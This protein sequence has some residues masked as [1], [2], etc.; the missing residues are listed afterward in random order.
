MLEMKLNK[1]RRLKDGRY[2]F[3]YTCPKTHKFK[4]MR[5]KN[6]QELSDRRAAIQKEQGF[7]GNSLL[8]DQTPL[9]E[10]LK[11]YKRQRKVD[12]A[13][14]K[15]GRKSAETYESQLGILEPYRLDDVSVEGGTWSFRFY[16]IR[17]GQTKI[18]R[19]D[20]ELDC[21][22]QHRRVL[23]QHLKA[24]E[25][26][27]EKLHMLKQPMSALT[28][29]YISRLLATL[30]RSQSTKDHYYVTIKN[31]VNWAIKR[32][33]LHPSMASEIND[34]KPGRGA[35]KEMQI[36]SEESVK[37]LIHR[38]CD[39]WKP[40][41]ALA[42]TVGPRLSE[43]TALPWSNVHLNEGYIYI[44]QKTEDDGTI[45]QLL[46][47]D[48]AYRSLPISSSIVQMLS[49]LPRNGKLVFPAAE[50]T[51]GYWKAN[52]HG[53]T[54]FVEGR[55]LRPAN[56][57]RPSLVEEVFRYGLQPILRELE[58][59]DLTWEGRI[60]SLRHFSAS[61]MIDQNWNVKRIQK[62]M[63]HSSAQITLDVYGHLMD[64]QTFA[65]EADALADGLI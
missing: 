40:F 34:A 25:H 57:E 51:K 20:N 19:T 36:P 12:V 44:G 28:A 30:D 29:D 56:V 33:Y 55:R 31:L 21:E 41:W 9:G 4:T 10:V 61:R 5:G 7:Q 53:R 60:H 46:K 63:G 64:R 58:D 52:Q 14:G 16:C 47:T 13:N 24:D 23:E 2:S 15:L 8:I 50:F 42:A 27:A 65:E 32:R 48:N 35:R 37:Q 39:F 54:T 26:R 17:R 11:I 38:S 62:R 43:L 6:K 22:R 49:Q 18:Y 59:D 45:S 1:I 3:R